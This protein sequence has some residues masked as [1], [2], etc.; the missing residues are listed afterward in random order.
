MKEEHPC[1]PGAS[2][3]VGKAD[4]REYGQAK[5]MSALE[6]DKY[7]GT[8]GVPETGDRSIRAGIGG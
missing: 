1:P 3:L 8:T 2:T 5:C 6:G 4:N 7:G